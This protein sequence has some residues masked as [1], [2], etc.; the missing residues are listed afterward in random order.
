MNKLISV[1]WF[2]VVALGCSSTSNTADV[3]D[4]VE[5]AEIADARD[6]AVDSQEVTLVTKD[7]GSLD[8][9]DT[10]V[11]FSDSLQVDLPEIPCESEGNC[12]L[13]ECTEN[14]DCQSGWCVEHMGQKVCTQTCQEECPDGWVC[15]QVATTRPDLTFV[16][17]SAYP[18]LCR[19]CTEADDC[20]GSAGTE[21]ACVAY[22]KH[23]AFCSGH[24]GDGALCPWGFHCA[25]VETVDGITLNQCISETGQC[26]CTAT[27]VQLG[28]Y[29]NCRN[30]SEIKLPGQT[31]LHRTGPH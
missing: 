4:M 17:V 2:V 31:G 9:I 10:L 28:L 13:D 30:D 19:P 21:D 14:S 16:C 1:V 27:S 11:D 29:T 6:L 25:A 3:P 5:H 12:F 24:C 22:G 26:P 23:G 7:Q 20:A 15:S 8:S 18:N